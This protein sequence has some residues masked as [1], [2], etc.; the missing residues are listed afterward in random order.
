MQCGKVEKVGRTRNS[1]S[2]NTGR[3]Y[4]TNDCPRGKLSDV[5][6]RGKNRGETVGFTMF[7]ITPKVR[8]KMT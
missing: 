2:R 8:Q 4:V 3:A 6:N 5:G 7:K 1:G